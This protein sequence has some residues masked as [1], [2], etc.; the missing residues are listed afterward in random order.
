MSLGSNIKALRL[1]RGE[2]LQQVADAVGASK[3]HIWELESGKSK[4]PGFELLTKIA[5]H[6]D[7]S[8]DYLTG[9]TSN[10]TQNTSEAIFYRDF[11]S[12]GIAEQEVVKS[13]VE[14]LKSKKLG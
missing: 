11:N 7:C 14:T 12:L 3:P 8:L 10:K 2:T 5:D 4:N 1:Q 9:H 6:F 13:L